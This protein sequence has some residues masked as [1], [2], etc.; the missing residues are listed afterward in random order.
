MQSRLPALRI[1]AVPSLAAR[2]LNQQLML[3]KRPLT[4]APLII[5][6][7]CIAAGTLIHLHVHRQCP[8]TAALLI[9]AVLPLVAHV[10]VQVHV[11]HQHIPQAMR[12]AT[13]SGP[14]LARG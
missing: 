3:P 1:R 10:L 7:H 5:A 2:L 12:V 9:P 4:A 6:A 14:R 8:L 11:R 13:N